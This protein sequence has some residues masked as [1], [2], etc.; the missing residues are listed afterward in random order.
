M[1]AGCIDRQRAVAG[2]CTRH[3]QA[4]A[5]SLAEASVQS[6]SQIIA[7]FKYLKLHVPKQFLQPATGWFRLKE[8]RPNWRKEDLE[9]TLNPPGDF[10]LAK[11]KSLENNPN[12]HRLV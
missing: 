3:K 2:S 7:L 8:S 10:T 5:A 1:G 9:E 4:L 11:L 6:S 12:L